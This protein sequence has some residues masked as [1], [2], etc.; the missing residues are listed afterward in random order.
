MRI[1]WKQKGIRG[2]IF[3][4]I[5][6]VGVPCPVKREI[7]LALEIPVSNLESGSQKTPACESVYEQVGL[8]SSV[9][10]KQTPESQAHSFAAFCRLLP[11]TDDLIHYPDYAVPGTK[12]PLHILNEQYLI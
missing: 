4:M 7:K 10:S 11:A 9:L 12:I 2:I 1:T 3:T 6:L 5:L 8:S